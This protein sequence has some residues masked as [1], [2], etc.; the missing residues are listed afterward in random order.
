[1]GENGKIPGKAAIAAHQNIRE[2][3]YWLNQFSGQWVK[4]RFLYDYK[5]SSRE[6]R[7][8]GPLRFELPSHL[9]SQLMKIS[10]GVDHTLH[11]ILTAGLVLLL[12]KHTGTIDI[13]TGTPI[14]RQAVD[15]SL[16]IN[17]V[18]VLRN[19]IKESMTFKELLL[20][21]RET[22]AR[23]TEHYRY[24]LEILKEQ[25]NI[26]G[27]G[28]DFPFFETAIL[29]QNIHDKSYFGD[30]PFTVLFSFIN[31]GS[32]L[33]GEVEYDTLRYHKSTIEHIISHF[34]HL[35]DQ[36]L[37]KPDA[38]IIDISPLSKEERNQVLEV[39]NST[40]GDYP[41]GKT[42][43]QLLEEQVE[44]TPD[45]VA[46]VGQAGHLSYKE[47]NEKANQLAR[48]LRAQGVKPDSIAAIMLE[49]SMEMITAILGVLKADGAYLPID[50]AAPQKRVESLLQDSRAG[51]LLTTGKCTGAF[52]FAAL[53]GFER[54]SAQPYLTPCRA[55][56]EDLDRLQ[57][58][59]RSL[60]DY[61][62]YR[63]FIGQAMVKNSITIHM[64][65]GCVYNC[66]YCFKIWPRKYILRS[67]ENVF[68]EIN[69]YYQLGI[70]RFAFVDDLP[71]INIKESS[72][73]FQLIIRNGLK[74]HLHFPNGIRGDILTP[75]Y[76]DLMVEAGTITMDLALETTSPRLQKL[77]R[78]NLNLK[79]L[80]E[81]IRYI[82][83]NHPQVILELQIL[84]GIPTES[85]EEARDSL[86]F[87]KRIK[88]VHFPYIHVL[89]I[90]P[91]SDMARIAV[92][93][94]ISREAI[95]RSADLAY[96]ELPETLPFPES[97]T[98]KYQAEF[99]N[100]YFMAKE[101]LLD[102]LP[103]QMKVLSEDE[104]VQ[105]YNSYLPVEINRFEEL[106]DYAGL[107]RDQIRGEFLPPDYGVV[108]GF[109]LE[110]K[111]YFPQIMPREDALRVLL[112]D[113]SQ[114]FTHH[115][116]IMYDV[117]EPPLGL[118]YL[119]THL[120]RTFGSR[121]NGKIVK[122]RIDFDSFEQ[123]KQLI[124]DF[125]PHVIGIRTLNF[126]K[127]FFHETIAF[128]KQW[129]PD[130]PIIAGGPYATSN[131]NIMLKDSAIDLAVVG[132]GEITFAEL[133]GKILE[134]NKKLPGPSVLKDIPG[135]AFLE[136][137]REFDRPGTREIL[138]MNQLPPGV[139]EQSLENPLP[140]N[141]SS[142]LAY[143]IYTSG[144][145]GIPKGVMI[146]HGNL[147]NQLTGLRKRFHFD[148]RLNYLLLAAF[149]FDVS[150]MH[151]FSPLIT[152]AKVHLIDEETR[153][154]SL[155]LWRFVHQK[156]IDILNIV[157]AY[158]KILLEN[159]EN[160]Q[161][162]LKYLFVGGD[163]FDTELYRAL[164]DTFDVEHIIN[165]YGPTETTIN[166][167]FYLCKDIE[168]GKSIPIGKPLMN[169]RAYI[170]D[171]DLV[172][173]PVGAAGELCIA[174]ESVAR[175]YLNQPEL[176]IEKFLSNFNR[177]YKSYRTYIPKKLYKTG[178]LARWLL[179]GNIE[180]LGRIDRQVKVR[181]FRI[182][183]GEIETQLLSHKRIKEAI[184]I[185][186][187]DDN[188]DKYLC[189]YIVPGS[190]DSCGGISWS[191][192][193]EYLMGQL[194][195]YMVPT[196]FIT[197]EKI[198]LTSTGKPDM[199]A[200]PG[201]G[202]GKDR[203]VYVAPRNES[204]EDLVEV[205]AEVMAVD[206][207]G[208]GIDT[209]FFDLGGHSLKATILISRIHKKLNIKIPLVELFKNP[210]IRGL[211][212][213]IGGVE[214]ETYA[215][216]DPVEKK[217]YYPLSS[218]QKRLVIVEQMIP[219]TIAYNMPYVMISEE[220]IDRQKL[221]QSSRKLIARHESLRTSF[222]MK[223]EVHVQRIHE[224]VDFEI[225]CFSME[226][227]PSS[228]SHAS[229]SMDHA[230]TIKAFI[231]PFD[232]SE[233]PLLRVGL[234]KIEGK[235][236][237]LMVD[238]HHIITDGTSQEILVQDVMAFYS[239]EEL[240]PL[241]LQY[242]DY[243]QWQ[244]LETWKTAV[245]QQETWWTARF[246]DEIPL[247]DL[248]FDY[249]R[250]VTQSFEGDR[251]EFS[252]GPAE[253]NGLKTLASREGATLYMVL[254]AIFNVFLSKISGKEDI[255]I[256]TP[257]AGRRHPDLK[258]IVGMFV[259]TLALRSQPL[260]HLTYRDFLQQVRENTLHA[261]E[262]QEYPFEELV[263]QISVE[264]DIGRNPLFDVV[265]TL[266]NIQVASP[267]DRGFT[268]TLKSYG[269]RSKISKFDMTL[270]AAELQGMLVF[271]LEYCT[272]LF[273]E[274]TIHRF[275]RYFQG[276]LFRV[277][278]E[279][280]I[281]LSEIEIINEEEKKQILVDF[282]ATSTG[283]H[284]DKTIHELFADQVEQAPDHIALIGQMT[285]KKETGAYRRDRCRWEEGHLSY[286]EL[287]KKSDQL[288]RLLRSKNVEP[289]DMVGIIGGRSMEMII[290]IL[291][292]LKTG[293]AYL[294]IDADYPE[295]RK[296]YMKADSRAKILL[297]AEEII[298]ASKDTAFPLR[299]SRRYAPG[300]TLAY[301]MYTSGS[302][303][304][305]KG[306]MVKHRNVVRLVK[307][308]NFVELNPGT[309][310]LQTGAPVFDATTFEIWGSLLN[311][312]QLALVRKDII[313]D[314]H[315]LGEALKKFEI[316]TL[317]LS[318]PLF[319]QLALE[320]IRLFSPLRYLLV[321]GDV[322]SPSHINKVKEEF[323]GLNIIN[324]YGPTENTTF[325]ATYLIEKEFRHN[326]PIGRP[327]ANSTA[328]IVGK[329]H[330]LQPI[331]VV[332]E[333]WVGGDGVSQGYLNDPGLTA[334]KFG[335]D[336]WDYRYY[337]DRKIK[338]FLGGPGG[339]FFK[340]APLAAGGKL[341]KTGD[342]AR[343]LP[344]GNV[345][346]LGRMDFQVKISGYRIE[347]GEIENHLL[348]YPGVKE[349]VVITRK[350]DKEDRYVAAYI[351]L[352]PG[353]RSDQIP[354]SAVVSQL[355]EFL[356]RDLPDYMIPAFFVTLEKIP[357]TPNG[358]VDRK[359]LPE[360]TAGER[361]E[362]YVAPRN[363]VE[364]KLVELWS[365]AL[366]IDKENISIDANFFQLGGNS[367]KAA[368]MTA[369]IHRTF[370]AKVSLGDIFKT[371]TVKDVALIISKAETTPF[372]DLE[373]V[374]EKEFYQLSYN[375]RRLWIISQL[376]PGTA[377]YN[378]PEHIVFTHKVDEDSLKK[379][380]HKIIQRHDSLRTGFK[381]IN[382]T[383]VQFVVPRQVDI[384]FKGIDLSSR[385]EN[386]KQQQLKQILAQE[387]ETPFDL[388]RPPLLRFVLVKVGEEE[389]H[390]AYN[391]HH[392]ISDGFSMQ[393][394]K[395][396]FI[397]LYEKYRKK[398]PAELEPLT[399]QY[400]DFAVWQDK[401]LESP[402]VKQQSHRFWKKIL[403]KQLVPV[404]LPLDSLQDSDTRE[405]AAYRCVITQ[406]TKDQLNQLAQSL[407]TSLF[408]VI[409][410]LF[411]I[412][413][414]RVSG[415]E[416][417][418]I[419]LPVS[420]RDHISF[421]QMVGFFVNTIIL[422]T[423]VDDD[424]TF[425][426]F[427]DKVNVNVLEA[428]QHQ[429]YPLE[430]VLDD[431]N[432]KFPQINVFFNMLNL[433]PGTLARELD[434]L[435]SYHAEESIDVKFDL[436]VY[437]SEY[438][439][440]IELVCNYKKAMFKPST[441]SSIMER[442]LRVIDFFTAHPGKRIFDY[443]QAKPPGKK[444]SLKRN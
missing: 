159:I 4:S 137:K 342:L 55:Q 324:G 275:I 51:C 267:R 239:G 251:L 209:N 348:K 387:A 77:V 431:L 81:N 5:T 435:E 279:P 419:G 403:E 309:R 360:P 334:E 82:T 389:F 171:S 151:I 116:R 56:V 347:L 63:P 414:S 238:L 440:G 444:R 131:Y 372:S 185:P 78:K 224:T 203:A 136:K 377:A 222:I 396:E 439:N 216:I 74:V 245:K 421:Q 257:V 253:T 147:V 244:T 349:A 97:F 13:L 316:N 405:G 232:L 148:S 353:G 258:P 191:E 21:I 10:R 121:I 225:E 33:E 93:H 411:N 221:E 434:S 120:Y 408:I 179:D 186:R 23:A 119:L 266:Y 286:K 406:K 102:V 172:P 388:T 61:E 424:I 248:P 38:A 44:K 359:M 343:W 442:Y 142:D 383:P 46:L 256:G 365:A 351:V 62:K 404:R 367:L 345:E 166:A 135:L 320:N 227:L 194:P 233:A 6:V 259:N 98:R 262:N 335:H 269:Y 271:N 112:L 190:V 19:Q 197:L 184:V 284:R 143:I 160:K 430:M 312:G 368:Q 187:E 338:S 3:D 250:P 433:D 180:F 249:P 330:H 287:D 155:K 417:I 96:H 53:R 48:F 407:H 87:I 73:L 327:I 18:L 219:G 373:I 285:G 71:N 381:A 441:I 423:H 165:I 90:Y 2:R 416:D 379:A 89:N 107:S 303:G 429:G 443:K 212:Q 128:I 64:S 24:P 204:E 260:N 124:D 397:Y 125:N 201:P 181:G 106:L 15:P 161:I 41:T 7:K 255:I 122:S 157:P 32:G 318:S 58:P 289:G 101:R 113:L 240:S 138:L 354:G 278:A 336:L 25:L 315:Q 283:Y 410:S 415:Q 292:I 205:W 188:G 156:R 146:Q 295:E 1:M 364:M 167:T 331:G 350:S 375:Q 158:M 305:P 254:L 176:T 356:S 276:V 103:Y 127:D 363:S 47:L 130:I 220:P 293:G 79:K 274:E 192:V 76:I 228:A 175:G 395:K 291:G 193:K 110:L 401:Q 268:Q 123:L 333:L 437:I 399:L 99:L 371:P 8:S 340:K 115:T 311:G 150:V 317:W 290:G 60:I 68:E 378:M 177:S 412:L 302:T 420:G 223:N 140:L 300:T 304:R 436:M 328:Y 326:I 52:S 70:R 438:K 339:R 352:S 83:E 398:Q 174:G 100:E 402:G 202:P 206:K 214:E 234:I 12:H 296:N 145:T 215:A 17:T 329:H 313:L 132:E 114:Y 9:V 282:N 22:I 341:Y 322:L 178:D 40:A 168:T 288:A 154:D 85:E 50:P 218:A 31:T 210:T 182:E 390:L 243:A 49:P 346:F 26:A 235:R 217:D 237:I 277:L 45:H 173:V 28:D 344:D 261:F 386:E 75:E 164:T 374:E 94:G 325:S 129:K 139:S 108:P 141:R 321:G 332:G 418:V 382:K 208:I 362:D 427:L 66:A 211:S 199:K 67:A 35:V 169:Y 133:I 213:Y 307:N 117:V 298:S 314:A 118:L 226:C 357:L 294:P 14:Y 299:L 393:I 247:L 126:Y 183:L 391:M 376:E 36:A 270:F 409:L 163:I 54:L 72:K 65:R 43:H 196:H 370:Q 104:L 241:Q 425:S 16:I 426:E 39:F 95:E 263:E 195:H 34:T 37:A 361:G 92:D 422:D 265:F 111:A 105:K 272:R 59:N 30:I 11:M 42:I 20:Q 27:P 69:L 80:E 236:D 355:R 273:R 144:S 337:H 301:V 306:V 252:I 384:P 189:A 264:R 319:N 385:E 323:P 308:T 281:R 162:R 200:L 358:K 91:N 242:K 297:T 134:N 369:R 57:F 109:N 230:S 198:P 310:I 366:G 29:L 229:G 152:G 170:L 380:I 428:L 86:E 432:M 153:K 207:G 392:I 231:R 84:H 280:G 246:R 394:M 88:W 413:L 149:T 400:K